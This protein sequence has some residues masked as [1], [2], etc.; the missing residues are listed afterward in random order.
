VISQQPEEL[1]QKE[2]EIPA[3]SKVCEEKPK[4]KGWDLKTAGTLA[5]SITEKLKKHEERTKKKDEQK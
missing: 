5:S 4:F 2:V 1:E 3:V